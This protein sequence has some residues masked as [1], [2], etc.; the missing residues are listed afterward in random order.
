MASWGIFSGGSAPVLTR[1]VRPH[2]A[3][4]RL[5]HLAIPILVGGPGQL[6]KPV[7]SIPSAT[8]KKLNFHLPLSKR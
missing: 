1:I 6:N 8:K 7:T 4:G 3:L 2:A 5:D